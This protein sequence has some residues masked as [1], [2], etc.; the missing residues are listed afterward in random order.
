[1]G[2]VTEP[3]ALSSQLRSD[4]GE[5][6]LLEVPAIQQKGFSMSSSYKGPTGVVHS[7]DDSG[8]GD[9]VGSSWKYWTADLVG[10][11]MFLH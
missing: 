11:R 4:A 5:E 7:E 9:L 10:F 1:M 3:G 8:G 2:L 6:E